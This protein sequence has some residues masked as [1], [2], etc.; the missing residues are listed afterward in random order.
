MNPGVSKEETRQRQD[1]CSPRKGTEME[2]HSAAL[3]ASLLTVAIFLFG[4]RRST[5]K[6]SKE[7]QQAT[8]IGGIE[9]SRSPTQVAGKESDTRR[10]KSAA[11]E[12]NKSWKNDHF[13]NDDQSLKNSPEKARLIQQLRLIVMRD[14]KQNTETNH[15][16]GSRMLRSSS[17]DD[18]YDKVNMH[19][20]DAEAK[21]D[22]QKDTKKDK[23]EGICFHDLH[24]DLKSSGETLESMLR[25]FLKARNW[26]VEKAYR[27]L[28]DDW[29]WRRE[30]D[31]TAL[32]DEHGEAVLGCRIADIWE[33]SPAWSQGSD[34][35]GRPVLYKRWGN[36]NFKRIKQH[37]T[38][39][40]FVRY[41]TWYVPY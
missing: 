35:Q 5:Q 4:W 34:T 30:E 24:R 10:E 37:T 40:R 7:A 20:R 14:N 15:G 27:M 23:I 22:V 31:I 32:A 38:L 21:R 3:L 19:V 36:F 28:R 13:M 25:R 16:D 9:I 33:W 8:A 17:R 1:G 12:S 41:H 26:D 11:A 29:R 2:L 18:R 39:H 6:E